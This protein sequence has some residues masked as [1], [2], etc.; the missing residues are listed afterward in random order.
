MDFDNM[1]IR[2]LTVINYGEAGEV[3]TVTFSPMQVDYVIASDQS[4][5]VL[6]KVLKHTNV[7][8]SS[9][10]QLDL[11]ISDI[12]LMNIKQAVGSYIL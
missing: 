5:E 1:D 10:N 7:I 8:F 11:F 3:S 4:V 2:E 12:D 9:G 6:G